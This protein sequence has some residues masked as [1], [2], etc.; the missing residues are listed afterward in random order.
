LVYGNA[1]VYGDARVYGAISCATRSDGYTFTIV[2][3]PQGARIIAGCWHFSID[4][5]RAHWTDTRGGTPLGEESLA[6][7]DCLE[8]LATIRGF[9]E[10]AKGDA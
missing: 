6:I 3:T 7:V 9:I 4:E 1:R 10:P 5:A 8:R 2:S